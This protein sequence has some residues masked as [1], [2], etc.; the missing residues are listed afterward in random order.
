[1]EVCTVVLSLPETRVLRPSMFPELLCQ[2]F[3]VPSKAEMINRV[4]I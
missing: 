4:F 2:H 1:M 3:A